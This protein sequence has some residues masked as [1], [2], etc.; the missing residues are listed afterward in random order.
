[1]KMKNLL[2]LILLSLAI[3]ACD[4]EESA[5]LSENNPPVIKAQNFS[6]SESISDTKTIGMVKATDEDDDALSFSI[7]K[8]SDDFFEITD[9]G[10]LSLVQG[11]SLDFATASRRNLKVS[12]SDGTVSAEADITIN[13]VKVDTE[14]LAP[15]IENQTFDATEDILHTT[16]IGA[17]DAT[18]P[19]GDNLIFT[20]SE[21]DS[22]LFEI[23][24]SGDLSLMEGQMLDFEEK[25]EHTITVNVSDGNNST[26]TTIT[27][28]VQNVNEAPEFVTGLEFEVPEDIDDTHVIGTVVASD[29][30]NNQLVFS[31]TEDENNLFEITESGELSLADGQNLDFEAA[32]FHEITVA[33]DDGTNEAVTVPVMVNVTEVVEANPNDPASFVTTWETTIA[34]ESIRIGLNPGYNYNFNINWGD[35]TVENITDNTYIQ[36]TYVNQGIHTVAILGDFPTIAMYQDDASNTSIKSVEQWGFIEWES[37]QRSFEFCLNLQIN[38]EDAPNLSQ[39]ADMSYMFYSPVAT[40]NKINGDLSQWDVSNVTDMS[41]MFHHAYYLNSDLSE[42]NVSNVTD[43]SY[44][45][46]NA[47]T[48]NSNIS[49]WNVGNVTDMSHMF[50]SASMFNQDI[51]NWNVGNV[52]NM[53][54]M[55]RS[56]MFNHNIGSWNVSN[57]LDMSGMFAYATSF[58]QNIEGWDV[59]S[60]IDMTGMFQLAT[61]FNQDIGNWNVG[62]VETMGLMFAVASSFNQDISEWNTVNVIDMSGMFLDADSFN[63]DISHWDTGNVIDMYRIFNSADSFNQ[64]LGGWDIGS[65]TQINNGMTDFFKNSGM[66]PNNY[67]ATLEGWVTFVSNNNGPYNIALGAQGIQYCSS[68]MTQDARDLLVND[69]GWTIEDAGGTNI[70]N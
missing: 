54:N 65:V 45:F 11:R 67:A 33:V 12:V 2:Y 4:K 19:E 69:Y 15:E 20:I 32:Q 27:I 58:N 7:A 46:Y 52:T 43:M 42:W 57:V 63:Q 55:F 34:N 16:V 10:A 40:N 50:Y 5:E 70:C 13:V 41:Y 9:E 36:H 56:T 21:N 31:I 38:A 48:F 8:N 59:S 23:T 17:V 6:A 62:N 14:N 44:M 49:G 68:Q 35:G 47:R 18:D 30:E 29:P 53:E 51:G 28:M 25:E 64:N 26:D 60:V 66:S 22:D 61:S 39:V 24:E 1:M 3:L 37:M